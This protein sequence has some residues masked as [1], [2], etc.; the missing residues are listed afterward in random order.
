MPRKKQ[1]VPDETVELKRQLAETEETLDAIRQ[2]MVDAFVIRKADGEHVVTLTDANFPY[3]MMVESMNEGAITLIPDGT[4]FYCNPCLASMVR[5]DPEKLIGSNFRDLL[6]PE[7]QLAF[8]E[9]FQGAG[10]N[11]R[12]RRVP[13]ADR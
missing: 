11:S 8:D 7:D 4:I 10:Q 13:F 2:Y 3:R 5:M 12:P 9:M 1:Q 6:F